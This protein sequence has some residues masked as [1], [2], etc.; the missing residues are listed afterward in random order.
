MKRILLL[1]VISMGLLSACS[2]AFKAGQTPDDVYYSPG[3]DG[4]SA[5]EE[6]V[7]KK[8]AEE[9]QEHVNIQDDRY[10][11]MKVAN[12]YRWSGIDNYDYWYDS[13]YDFGG[14]NYQ[15]CYS[16]WNPRWNLGLGY[17][18]TYPG[19]IGWGWASPIYTV[20]AYSTASYKSEKGYTSGANISAYRNKNYNN[21][22]YGFKDP[23][24]GTFIPSNNN[25]SF[26]NLLKRVFSGGSENTSGYERASS[27]YD[28]PAR[29]YSTTPSTNNSAPATSGSAGG[30]S[31]GFQST[32]SSTSTG[33]GGRG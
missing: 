15:N 33:R 23:K 22:N 26:G 10:L 19:S 16:S 25:N 30:T 28:R 20:V 5:K 7:K 4:G 21:T 31:G 18:R 27:S 2:T 13:R 1:S 8:Q 29:S 12:R 32:G 14:Y 9:Y 24:T 6:V 3:R 11:R 17:G